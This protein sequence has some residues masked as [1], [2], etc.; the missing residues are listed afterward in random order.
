MKVLVL[1][2]FLS[3]IGFSLNAQKET[4]IFGYAPAYIGQEIEVFI[5]SDQFTKTTLSIGKTI[6]KAD[7]TFLVKFPL[8]KTQQLLLTGKKNK[9]TLYAQPGAEYQVGLPDRSEYDP[10][11]PAGNIVELTFVGLDS[12]DINYKILGFNRVCD[13]FVSRHYTLNNAR[14]IYYAKRL[15]SFKVAMSDYYKADTLDEFFNYHRKFSFARIDNM[16]FNGARNKYEKFDFYLRSTPVDISS[17]AYMSYVNSYYDKFYHHIDAKISEKITKGI[18]A[19]SPTMIMKSLGTEYT[20]DHN[21]KLREFV[22]IKMLSE[23]FYDK[24]FDQKNIANAIDSIAKFG[25]FE[26][27]RIVAMNVKNI[28]LSLTTGGKAPDF[29]ASFNERSIN[30]NS[31]SGKHLYLFFMSPT[32]LESTKQ[33]ELLKPIYARY[34]DYVQFEMILIRPEGISDN[35][36]RLFYESC[37]WKTT[38][39]AENAQILRDYQVKTFPVYHLID[40]IGYFAS[41]PALGPVPNS[42][43][44]TIDKVFFEL[45]KKID[46]NNIPER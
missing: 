22:M 43:Y 39:V 10:Y 20:M 15:D 7:S 14:N 26:D 21:I 46:Q 44:E 42:T 6:V 2:S 9:T 30:L 33:V 4:S 36:L 40:P 45:K 24:H 11:R 28:L 32:S 5:Y 12:T 37:P 41:T 35:E 3:F 19:G 25:K 1:I 29:N 27:N 31:Y 34:K 38:V 13:D 17:D 23:L 18:N 8:K 16:R